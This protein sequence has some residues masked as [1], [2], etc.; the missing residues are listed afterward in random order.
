MKRASRSAR[1][2]PNKL[3]AALALA[4]VTVLGGWG[5]ARALEPAFAPPPLKVRGTVVWAVGDAGDGSPEAGRL[6][7]RIAAGAPDRLLYLGDVYELGTAQDFVERYEPI[8]GELAPRTAPTPGN[9]EWGNR[10]QGYEPYWQR[11][12]GRPQPPHYAFSLGGWELISLNSEAP[13]DRGSPQLRWL[14]EHLRRR[15]P[16]TCR[17]AFWHRPRFSAGTVHGDQDDVDPLWAAL[18]GRAA[19]VVNGHEHDSQRFKPRYGMVQLVAG[20]GRGG[21]PLHPLRADPRLA[22]GN[23]EDL[24]ALRLELRPGRARFAFV[25]ADGRKLDSGEVPCVAG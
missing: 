19:L 2:L 1:T 24:A 18:R 9:H 23:D 3:L 16:G 20:A 7:D 8:L 25:A 6:A 10:K 11:V 22:F 14:G 4:A 12:H 13:H 5:L 21:E 17:L 15:A